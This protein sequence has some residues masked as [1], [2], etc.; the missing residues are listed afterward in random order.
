MRKSEKSLSERRKGCPRRAIRIVGGEPEVADPG[1]GSGE[2]ENHYMSVDP[3]MRP[4]LRTDP[5]RAYDR[6]GTIGG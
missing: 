4:R 6:D 2:V 1:E 5:D 3:A